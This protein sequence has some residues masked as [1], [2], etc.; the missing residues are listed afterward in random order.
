MASYVVDGKIIDGVKVF[1]VGNEPTTPE[2]L[3]SNN[4]IILERPKGSIE[5]VID[6]II[7]WATKSPGEVLIVVAA[8]FLIRKVVKR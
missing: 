2:P 7:T 8:L 5:S 6:S 4:T 1:N 3:K